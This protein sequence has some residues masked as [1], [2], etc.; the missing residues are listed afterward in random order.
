MFPRTADPAIISRPTIWI[1]DS[2]SMDF[3]RLFKETRAAP[4]EIRF[5]ATGREFLRQWSAG[6]PDVCIVNVR[7]S[8][9]NGFD[10]IEMI[11]P[12][13]KGAIVCMLSDSYV[14]DDEVHALSLGVHFY[15]CKPLEKAVLFEFCFCKFIYR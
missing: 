6:A 2:R 12:F 10:L 11:Q 4:L 8:D 15:L 1:V 3:D 9:L 5:L 13:P 7:L 14:I